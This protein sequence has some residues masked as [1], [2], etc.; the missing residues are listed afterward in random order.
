MQFGAN[1]ERNCNIY[2]SYDVLAK[3]KRECLPIDIGI[4]ERSADVNLQCHV[5]HTVAHMIKG[6]S[7]IEW[8]F[9]EILSVDESIIKY[10]RQYPAK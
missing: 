1:D 9:H 7:P 5:D 2:P 8:V 4:T 10:F 6:F 3:S